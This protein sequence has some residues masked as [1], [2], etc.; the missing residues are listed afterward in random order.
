MAAK[1]KAWMISLAK[2]PR[3]SVPDSI[4]AE[5]EAKAA[6]LIAIV[7]KPKH[8][9]SP[10]EDERFNYITDIGG[11]W[12]SNYFYFFSIYACPGYAAQLF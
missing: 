5:V 7:L 11:K 2:S 3:P 8:I 9:R 10:Q 12:Y 1:R 6:D 4:K